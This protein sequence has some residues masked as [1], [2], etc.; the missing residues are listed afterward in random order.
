MVLS[1]TYIKRR[2]LVDFFGLI[3]SGCLLFLF[4][5]CDFNL[6]FILAAAI[7]ILIWSLWSIS[8]PLLAYGVIIFV[9]VNL[10][11]RASIFIMPLEGYT[12][13][14]SLYLGNIMLTVFLVSN[15]VK[16]LKS[17]K[18]VR[19]IK[20][21]INTTIFLFPYLLFSILLPVLGILSGQW[22]LSYAT[23]AIRN[24]QWILIT[25]LAYLLCN[26]YSSS[27]VIRMTFK[28]L[29]FSCCLEV[30][31]SVLQMVYVYVFPAQYPYLDKVFMET[32]PFDWLK[33]GRATGLTVNPNSLGLQGLVFMSLFFS[34][35]LSGNYV[36]A[37]L[38]VFLGLASVW[39]IVSSGS[40]TALLTLFAL[41]SFVAFIDVIKREKLSLLRR[42]GLVAT[43]LTSGAVTW[44]LVSNMSD[45]LQTR[46]SSVLAIP[47]QGF[48]SDVSFGLR[49][50]TWQAAFVY[51]S[52]HPFGSLVPPNYALQQALDSYWVYVIVQGSAIYLLMFI[53]FIAAVITLAVRSINNIEPMTRCA[54]YF[55]LLVVLTALIGGISMATFQDPM[56]IILLYE[57]IGIA[58]YN[59][60]KAIRRSLEL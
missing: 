7:L 44:A 31:Y 53:L 18:T 50:E 33:L 21:S 27:A 51:L 57:F 22:P 46:L 25:V 8:N 15:F 16:Y 40:R 36:N 11:Y 56:V 24:M 49:V 32:H 4:T 5:I 28:V 58:I 52:E 59:E 13:R 29:L 34:S 30:S 60:S 37:W 20:P 10:F 47:F 14:G 19:I 2:S 43:I 26:K 35:L 55:L 45:R 54:G 23:S 9:W 1:K 3:V 39:L 17:H 48:L 41:L 6:W 12:N 42:I 38:R